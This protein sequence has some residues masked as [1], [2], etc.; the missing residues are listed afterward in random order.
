MIFVC[1]F[2]GITW[3]RKGNER[4]KSDGSLMEMYGM[5][6]LYSVDFCCTYIIFLHGHCYLKCVFT[7]TYKVVM[8]G[9]FR[10]HTSQGSVDME[11]S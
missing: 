1:V 6:T 8:F 2:A 10:I 7:C 9:K 3:R 4:L 5:G 11:L